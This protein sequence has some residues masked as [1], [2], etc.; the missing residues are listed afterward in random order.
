MQTQR[1]PAPQ[2]YCANERERLNYP[3]APPPAVERASLLDEQIGHAGY[4]AERL[5]S[6]EYRISTLAN[7]L[8]GAV[9]Q[10]PTDAGSL[11]AKTLG[12][13]PALERLTNAVRSIDAGH[14][15]L[16]TEPLDA[17]EYSVEGL[18][19]ILSTNPAWA[20]G[21]PLAA[22]GFETQRYRKE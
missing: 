5:R 8:V 9:P 20:K 17:P 11:N 15:E 19:A 12:D 16:V 18:S 4:C 3:D 13:P 21:L 1:I 2:G 7:R 14:D 10:G 6:M 22:A